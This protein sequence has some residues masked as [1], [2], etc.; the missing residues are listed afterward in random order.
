MTGWIVGWKNKQKGKAAE[1]AKKTSAE[2]AAAEQAKKAAV[3]AKK[4]QP[5]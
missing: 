4:P 1:Q 3:E 2:T 5:T